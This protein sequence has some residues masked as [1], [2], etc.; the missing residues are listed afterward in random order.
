MSRLQQPT[1]DG[2]VWYWWDPCNPDLDY[3][4]ICELELVSGF[5]GCE[6]QQRMGG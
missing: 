1:M 6:N 2:I 3:S 5:L 4:R